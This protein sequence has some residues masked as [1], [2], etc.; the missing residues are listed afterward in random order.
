MRHELTPQKG[1][2]AVN[3]ELLNPLRS[4]LARVQGLIDEK[5]TDAQ[6]KWAAFDQ[7]RATIAGKSGDTGAL[8][9]A[10]AVHKEYALVAAELKQ[11]EQQREG[12][13]R[14]LS[15]VHNDGKA[16]GSLSAGELAVESLAY[17]ELQ[18]SGA[19]RS[20]SS[21][22]QAKLAD[23]SGAEFKTLIT[24]GTNGTFVAPDHIGVVAQPQRAPSILDL[25]AIG[26]TASDTVEYA[27]QTTY[28]NAAAETAEAAS[29]SQGTKPEATIAF[30]K[31]SETV[32]TIAH[33][34]PATRRSVA[35]SQQLKQV[36]DSVLRYGV[37]LRLEN[38]IVTGN[39]SGE[40]FTGIV[41]TSGIQTQAA[42]SDSVVDA[43]HKGLTKLALTDVTATGIA[44]HPNDWE[45]ARLL[46]DAGGGTAG[47]GAYLMGS[48][49]DSPLPTLWGLPVAVTTAVAENTALAGDWT[50][51]ALWT[52][53]QATVYVTDAHLDWFQHNILA[54][55]CEARAA[56]SVLTPSAF[57]KITGV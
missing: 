36:I 54:L 28:T 35:D 3:P 19:L 26:E 25:I 30:E 4:E 2:E 55:L 57:V 46:R 10:E 50:Q 33:F 12:I 37:R 1:A 17:K 42:G 48:P 16:G 53:E 56:F 22:I 5:R 49:G 6:L 20:D 45:A 18:L 32:R 40:N 39:G 27:R 44:M 8:D 47:T 38:Q 7:A 34:V 29:T 43:I 52:R 9:A 24:S 15:N 21:R 51:A 23:L 41:N 31:V 14:G 11:L 13:F